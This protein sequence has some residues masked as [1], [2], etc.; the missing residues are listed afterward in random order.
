MGNVNEN[1]ESQ[2]IIERAEEKTRVMGKKSR[3]MAV[4]FLGSIWT[5]LLDMIWLL[6]GVILVSVAIFFAYYIGQR[7]GF[8]H[9]ALTAATNFINDKFLIIYQYFSK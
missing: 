6:K 8:G 1:K 5:F 7:F 2:N 4:N 3:K 9:P